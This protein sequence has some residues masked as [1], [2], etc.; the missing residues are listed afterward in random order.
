MLF[1]KY[2]EIL[3]GSKVKVKILRALFRFQTKIF[4]SRELAKQIKVSHTAVLKSLTDLQDMN[5]IK[6][7][8]HGTSNLITLN[9]ESHLYNP[10][11]NLFNFELE[12]LQNLEEEIRKILPKAKSVA[13]FGSIALKKEKPNSDIDILIITKD[14]SE[15]NEII[16]K[17]QEIFSKKFGNVIS[18]YIMTE[19]E[20]KRKRNT[21]FVKDL[22]QNYVLIKGDKL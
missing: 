9:K 14:K 7:E 1:S 16:A 20:L 18:A 12:T 22:L 3:L 6:I 8:S 15:V 19:N 4:T 10:I 17:K 21:A 5:I 13:L 11:A 2:I